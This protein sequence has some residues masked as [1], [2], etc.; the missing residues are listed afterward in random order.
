M[1]LKGVYR[2]II[3]LFV[4]AL[5]VGCDQVTKSMMRSHITY[6]DHYS[7]FNGHVTLLNVE[8]TGAFL[9]MGDKLAG[10]YRFI[11]LTVLPLLALLSGLVY[12]ILK[13]T[14]SKIALLGIISVI[15]GG[16][17]NLYDRIMHGS[18]T[19]F[20]HIKFGVFQTG[21]FNA[22]DVSIMVGVG[23]MMVDAW[24]KKKQEPKLLEL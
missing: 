3:I 7:F 17:G 13:N 19:D 6:Y 8:N 14:F 10:P 21:V 9:S 24:M 1:K 23:L 2:T 12:I 16:I 20:M 5:N 11:L 22:A 4:L 15:G 18:V